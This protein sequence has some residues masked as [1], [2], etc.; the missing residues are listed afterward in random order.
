MFQKVEKKKQFKNTFS[1]FALKVQ[2][3]IFMQNQQL[4]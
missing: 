2:T 3:Y 4:E 1:F